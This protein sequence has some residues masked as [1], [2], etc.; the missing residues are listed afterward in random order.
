MLAGQ[1]FGLGRVD[2]NVADHAAQCLLNQNVVAN[3]IDR[4]ADLQ[5]LVREC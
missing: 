4:H 5:L 3:V 2:K 1:A